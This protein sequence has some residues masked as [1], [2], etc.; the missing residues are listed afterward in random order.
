MPHLRVE[1]SIG[2]ASRADIPALCRA[3]HGAMA[4]CGVFPLAGIRVRAFAADVAIVADGLPENDFAAMELSV[5]AGR[6][7][8][9]RPGGRA[10]GT[11]WG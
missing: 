6:D 2:L 3:L 4:D 1:Y 7:T 8:A 11:R 10:R 9:P 5:G